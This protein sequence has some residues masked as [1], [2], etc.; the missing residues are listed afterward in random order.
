MIKVNTRMT[1]ELSIQVNFLIMI[2]STK[3]LLCLEVLTITLHKTLQ[4]LIHNTDCF[5]L[6]LF[7]DWF[8]QFFRD[9]SHRI[10]PASKT[11]ADI[12]EQFIT[13][14]LSGF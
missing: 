6:Y 13:K 1:V 4:W 2:Y 9:I 10:R 5:P 7:S 8:N 12:D 3:T 11:A 14:L